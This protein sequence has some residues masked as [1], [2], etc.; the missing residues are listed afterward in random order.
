MRIKPFKNVDRPGDRFLSEVECWRLL[1]A[2][3][4]PLRALVSAALYTRCRLGELLR[5]TSSDVDGSSV[6]IR[7]S[8]S[9]KQRRVPLSA[10]GEQFFEQQT[11]SKSSAAV[12]FAPRVAQR[13]SNVA[14]SRAMRAATAAANITPSVVFR[15]LRRTY[16]SLL[17]NGGTD[18][19][20]IQ[21]LL[22]HADQRMTQRVYARVL[23]KTL[24]E[25]T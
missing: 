15:D 5:M 13:W 23:D 25:A 2:C 12:L 10:E 19:A 22:G 7:H 9:G 20:V 17:I 8:K 1:N 4:L 3:E 16:G 11:V 18:G 14:V 24:T 21:R 6:I